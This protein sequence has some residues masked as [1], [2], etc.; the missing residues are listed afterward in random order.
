[1]SRKERRVLLDEFME[2]WLAERGHLYG[3]SRAAAWDAYR[4]AK[5]ARGSQQGEQLVESESDPRPWR[6]EC[7]R[8]WPKQGYPRQAQVP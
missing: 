6:R 3:K 8:S 5:A 2:K 4:A 7:S 1:M